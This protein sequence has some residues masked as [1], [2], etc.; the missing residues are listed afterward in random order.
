MVSFSANYPHADCILVPISEGSQAV[1]E[2]P[3]GKCVSEQSDLRALVSDFCAWLPGH[4]MWVSLPDGEVNK[5]AAGS[6][7]Q[8]CQKPTEKQPF[9]KVN[10]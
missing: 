1:S 3:T 7:T 6:V 10:Q 4:S 2:L 9:G 5:L 8:R